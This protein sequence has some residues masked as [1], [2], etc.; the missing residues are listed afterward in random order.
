M[1]PT[2]MPAP[3][4]PAPDTARSRQAINGRSSRKSRQ[5]RKLKSQNQSPLQ[6]TCTFNVGNLLPEL[7]DQIFNEVEDDQHTH[8][9]SH[10][11]QDDY[12]SIQSARTEKG[13]VLKDGQLVCRPKSALL[14]FL[15]VCKG[16]KPI[17]ERRLYQSIAI[18]T[19]H[20]RSRK[21]AVPLLS[22]TLK[23]NPYL[24]GLVRQLRMLENSSQKSPD[25]YLAH[26]AIVSACTQLSHLTL[27]GFATSKKVLN[28]LRTSIIGLTSLRTLVLVQHIEWA[29]FD[30]TH[31]GLCSTAD[32][33]QWMSRWR[34]IQHVVVLANAKLPPSWKN[35]QSSDLCLATNKQRR[36][37]GLRKSAAASNGG[38]SSE[39]SSSSQQLLS[40]PRLRTFSFYQPS[41]SESA[42][43]TLKTAAPSLTTLRIDFASIPMHILCECLATWAPTLHTLLLRHA[44]DTAFD[45]QIENALGQ[46][47]NLRYLHT[48]ANLVPPQILH[49]LLALE[50]LQYLVRE[51]THFDMLV[52]VVPAQ[53]PNLRQF[54]LY[55]LCHEAMTSDR[56][57]ILED[58]EHTCQA[59]GILFDCKLDWEAMLAALEQDDE[60]DDDWSLDFEHYADYEEHYGSNSD[61]DDGF[62]Y[63]DDGWGQSHI[64]FEVGG[65]LMHTAYHWDDDYHDE[66]DVASLVGQI[67]RSMLN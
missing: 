61:W 62:S 44:A 57:R 10:P 5:L 15:R 6:P 24:A 63:W 18:G 45:S 53:L 46:L 8:F 36:N 2:S 25:Q 65:Q 48:T 60:F 39:A 40:F 28:V 67:R 49:H 7:L 14:P 38:S 54:V 29:A 17:A 12:L 16:W 4:N 51:V 9:Q 43:Q 59:H 33:L 50:D 55:C 37:H 47:M 13:T 34:D 56:L 26:A 66:S 23:G 32:I 58:L 22:R 42:L 19:T 11:I 31:F 3:S 1:P 20:H 52:E 35:G 27:L 21:S 41:I 64:T 30:K